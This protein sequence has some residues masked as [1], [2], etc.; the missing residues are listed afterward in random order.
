[1]IE[2]ILHL[3]YVCKIKTA[4]NLQR[5]N[6]LVMPL[7]QNFVVHFHASVAFNLKQFRF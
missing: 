3:H 6:S 1:M 4:V 7:N 2:F 5:K